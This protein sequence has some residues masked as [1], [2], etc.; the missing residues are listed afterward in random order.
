MKLCKDIPIYV[1]DFE[2]ST[3]TG[4]IEYGIVGLLNGEIFETHTKICKSFAKISEMEFLLHKIS[5]EETADKQP[6]SDNIDL[7]IE[8]RKKGPFCAHNAIFEEKLLASNFPVVHNIPTFFD[9]IPRLGWGPW[10]D[11]YSIYRRSFPK[12]KKFTLSALINSFTLSEKLYSIA[13]SLCPP[14]RCNYHCA[15]FDAIASALLLNNFLT[16]NPSTLSIQSLLIHSSVSKKQ[17][18]LLNQSYLQI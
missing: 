6:F 12:L 11:T 3:Q 15:L 1:I 18:H 5:F 14:T 2:G 17:F 13:K 4:I 8:K 7:F 16:S 10:V 9:N